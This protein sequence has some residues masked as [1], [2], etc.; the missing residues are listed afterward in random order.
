MHFHCCF[1]AGGWYRHCFYDNHV[2]TGKSD[3]LQ[4]AVH[5][6]GYQHHDQEARE[7]EARGVQF[8]KP[9]V[10]R[11]MG[12]RHFLVRR[13][14][15]CALHRVQVLALRVEAASLWRRTRSSPLGRGSG[16]ISAEHSSQRLQH[17]Q[18][19]LVRTRSFHA[20]RLWHIP[21][22]IFVYAKWE[23]SNY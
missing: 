3:R 14:Q 2:W 17:P 4:Q 8:P 9:L 22:V 19:S 11:N 20:T 16:S 15:H 18:Q 21:Q 1:P 5:V 6:F 10:K 23:Y 13:G 7:A 12:V